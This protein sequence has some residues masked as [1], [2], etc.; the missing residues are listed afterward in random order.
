M[1]RL[2]DSRTVATAALLIGTACALGRRRRLAV[3]AVAGPGI[4]GVAT[5]VLKRAIGR[6]IGG[7]YAFPS[8]HAGGLTALAT[9]VGLVAVG[10]AEPAPGP[11]LCATGL[12]TVSGVTLAGAA[13]AVALVANDEHRWTEAVGGSSTAV[14]VVLGTGLLIDRVAGGRSPRG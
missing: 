4:T 6:R 7:G 12:A 9:V 11:G 14:G 5:T 1:I 8:G 10:H 2:G 3:L 13:M